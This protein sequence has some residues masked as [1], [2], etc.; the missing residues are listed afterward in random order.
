MW[1]I[2]GLSPSPF[3]IKDSWKDCEYLITTQS[4][5]LDPN[6]PSF[7]CG[8]STDKSFHPVNSSCI[9]ILFTSVWLGKSQ[10]SHVYTVWCGHF[11]ACGHLISQDDHFICV[12]RDKC[13]NSTT[14]PLV[15]LR[16]WSLE[17]FFSLH[18]LVRARLSTPYWFSYH[19]YVDDPLTV[20]VLHPR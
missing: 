1:R 3:F 15:Y 5:L 18:D 2:T 14:S 9:T 7:K 12:G 8:H 19:W 20:L 6:W 13:P 4:N 17:S 10:K 11:G 16:S